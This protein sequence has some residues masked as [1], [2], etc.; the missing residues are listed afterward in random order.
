MTGCRITM[1]T[2]LWAW[3]ERCS[4][5]GLPEEEDPMRMDSSTPG[6][7]FRAE[8]KGERQA[9][10]ATPSLPITDCTLQPPAKIN[11][12]FFKSFPQG[13]CNNS[14]SI[15]RVPG[16]SPLEMPEGNYIHSSKAGWCRSLPCVTQVPVAEIDN[17]HSCRPGAPISN[18]AEMT[19][20][21]G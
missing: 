18:S 11:P 10:H 4:Q 19:E 9:K 21:Q 13:F 8:L 1:A 17:R 2:N 5:K 20:T 7:G 14:T 15:L 6:L 12:P 3:L 16:T